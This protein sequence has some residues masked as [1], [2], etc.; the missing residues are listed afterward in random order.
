[1]QSNVKFKEG[2]EKLARKI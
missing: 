2:K 1:M